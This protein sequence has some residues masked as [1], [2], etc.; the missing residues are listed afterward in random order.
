MKEKLNSV[1]SFHVY[2]K[3][4]NSLNLVDFNEELSDNEVGAQVF[5]RY[6]IRLFNFHI[7]RIE[8]T[9]SHRYVIVFTNSHSLLI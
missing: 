5:F 9:T 4:S 6:S 7:S 2:L 3:Y 8:C 1:C